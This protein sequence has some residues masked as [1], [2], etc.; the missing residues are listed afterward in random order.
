MFVC[1]HS[2]ADSLTRARTHKH[3]HAHDLYAYIRT[4][5]HSARSAHEAYN[6]K[7]EEAKVVHPQTPRGSRIGRDATPSPA[8]ARLQ[9]LLVQS[10]VVINASLSVCIGVYQCQFAC[11]QAPVH[12]WQC[13]CARARMYLCVS[14]LVYSCVCVHRIQETPPYLSIY[15]SRNTPLAAKH[16]LRLE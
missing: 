3:A 9:H 14:V 15:R 2:L 12:G 5:D 10:K 7:K 1:T 4:D 13:V 16:R 8:V 11:M 6:L